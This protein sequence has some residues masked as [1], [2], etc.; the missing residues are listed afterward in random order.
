MIEFVDIGQGLAGSTL[1]LVQGVRPLA[2]GVRPA[3]DD[4]DVGIV[5]KLVIGAVA[6][7]LDRAAVS[8]Q[9]PSRRL[10][11]TGTHVVKE[12]HEIVFHGTR[13]PHVALRRTVFLIVYDRQC[14]FVHLY[15]VS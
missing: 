8:A 9:D 7:R 13:T 15:V 4:L 5:L 6:I 1:V 14:T 12:R 11:G 3:A 10:V 2:P